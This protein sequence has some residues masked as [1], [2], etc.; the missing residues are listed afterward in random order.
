MCAAV[1]AFAAV[2]AAEAKTFAFAVFAVMAV[3]AGSVAD[4]IKAARAD[5]RSNC[6]SRIARQGCSRWYDAWYVD[7]CT[8]AE[9]E[10]IMERNIAA[11]RR[12]M[13]LEPGLAAPHSD[14]GVSF[15]TVGR[16]DE[17]KKEFE[18]AIAAG[19]K[20]DAGRRAEA[21]WEMA[22]ILW[23]EGDKK[24]AKKL[25]K[26]VAETQV[27]DRLLSVTERAKYIVAMAADHDADLDMMK[28]P[29]STDC[30]PFPTPQEAK[31]GENKVSLARVEI[32][33]GTNGTYGTDGTKDPIMRLLKKK[34]LRFG[35]KFEKGGTPIEIEISPDAPVDKPEGYSLSV[36]D[37]KVRVEAR[38]RLGALW[39]VVS[40]IQCVERRDRPSICEMAIR[41][42]PV[43]QRRGV[44]EYWECDFLEF[45]LFN[46]MSTLTFNMGR[47]TS[48][49]TLDR[50]RYMIFAKRLRDFGIEA[51]F[52][53]R[54]IAMNPLL[55]L[56]SERTWKL[57]LERAMFYG[58]IGVGCSFH[59]DDHRFPLPKMDIEAAGTAA[60]LDG[61][62][63]TKLYRTVKAKYPGFKMQFCPPFYWGPRS[64]ANY[65]EPR[66]EYLKSLGRDLDQDIDV[67]WTGGSV[68]SDGMTVD[69]V[70]WFSDLIG[71]KPTVFHN[72][73]CI[74]QHN[75]LQ[76]GADMTGYKTSHSPELFKYLASFQHNMSSYGEA[77][78]IGSAM[79]W[80]WNPEAHD[81]AIAVRRAIDQL[82]GPGVSDIIRKATPSI[83]HFDG[84]VYGAPRTELLSEDQADIDRRVADADAAWNGVLSIAKNGGRFVS[85]F[86]RALGWARQLA[87]TR[88]NPPEWLTQQRD[89]EMA[90][91][92]FA[93]AEVGYD[94][95]MG[96]VFVPGEMLIGGAYYKVGGGDSRPAR[97]VKYLAPG[98]A[99]C[100]RFQ[101][102]HFPP[103][104]PFK[105]IFVATRMTTNE[106]KVEV[107][108][109]GR[110]L[111]SGITPESGWRY[112]AF[113]IEIPVD[114]LQRSNVFE[115][116]NTSPEDD[117][118]AKAIVHY[119]V[120]RKQGNQ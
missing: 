11:H 49:N 87:E 79:D 64:P 54:D 107:V 110:V 83:S 50:V 120:I 35:A 72:G 89:A 118:M 14:L 48:L 58:S 24:G 5:I 76:Y 33:F 77:S 115:I 94:E 28:L 36:A 106:P 86:S 66:E 38:S 99:A 88:R 65:P 16:I 53:I 92:T 69:R 67:Y 101:C 22:S 43:Y 78:E 57:H 39:G 113:E 9:R 55:P 47:E 31:Y 2:H 27:A 46:K 45:A 52:M 10:A 90:N 117:P 116:R 96:D 13:A 30:K 109:N 74:G 112:N 25:L 29:H 75:F 70:T 102:L 81:P 15:A 85:G 105:L 4:E 19:D 20:M 21:R 98:V 82:E 111:K 97:G 3:N 6:V 51:H 44:I 68:K 1:A 84:Y 119:V 108:V 12:W 40:L 17:A 37:G 104:K 80:T 56:T 7:N 103:D 63:M 42:W 71:R 61:K 62:Y 73:N 95:S 26:E 60:N 100:G 34:L 93:K 41:D 18:I 59:L 32:K 8:K 23:D 114:A 91:T